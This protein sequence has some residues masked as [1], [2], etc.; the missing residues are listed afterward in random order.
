MKTT[1]SKPLLVKASKGWFIKYTVNG[2]EKR[3]KWKLNYIKDLSERERKFLALR[4][5]I[6][7]KLIGGWIPETALP[8]YAIDNSFAESLSLMQGLDFALEKKK[9]SVSVATYK[10]YSG[11]VKFCK[12]SIIKLGYQKLPLTETKRIHVKNILECAK[13]TLTWSG[14]SYN[15]NLGYLQAVMTELLTW[16]LIEVNPAHR[17]KPY[18]VSEREPR[19][20][21]TPEEYRRIKALLKEVNYDF[22]RF[23][24]TLFHTGIR[25]EELTEV[26]IKDVDLQK[27]EIRLKPL[28]TKTNKYRT[29]AMPMELHEFLSEMELDQHP[30]NFYL[31]GSFKPINVQRTKKHKDFIPAP[32]RV[33]RS[34]STRL[35]K[36]YV[37]DGL[38]INVDQYA[39]KHAGGNAMLLS[40][41]SKDAI[42]EK[43]GHDS[44]LST[45]IYLT[46]LKGTLL[47]E[48]KDSNIRFDED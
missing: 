6:E 37:K 39:Q 20:T 15:K 32:Y 30:A 40:G 11:T 44:M 31:F 35:W 16:H 29:V 26:K 1:Y 4:D 45:E 12:A 19:R 9:P 27:R 46:K 34:K 28:Y 5:L 42:K 33:T 17:Q 48:I 10:G 24:L 23:E 36:K 41:I 21:A 3:E 13:S 25:P 8:A 18:A 7:K 38:G 43:Y 2:K 14:E 47:D 22:F